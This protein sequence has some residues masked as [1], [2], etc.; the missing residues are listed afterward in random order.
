LLRRAAGR[1]KVS[2]KRPGFT[3]LTGRAKWDPWQ[4]VRGL[5]QEAAMQ[6]Y[7]DRVEKLKN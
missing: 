7:I 1:I 2:G 4:K 3:D 6:S 5:S